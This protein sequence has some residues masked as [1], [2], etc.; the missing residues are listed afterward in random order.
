MEPAHHLGVKGPSKLDA[1]KRS[2]PISNGIVRV[3]KRHFQWEA[4]R[5]KIWQATDSPLEV[6]ELGAVFGPLFI[7][8]QAEIQ[9]LEAFAHG[10]CSQPVQAKGGWRSLEADQT[11]VERRQQ[12]F[13]LHV[14]DSMVEVSH[15]K[16]TNH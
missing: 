15:P 8:Q 13:E 11:G 5:Y 4:D 7:G 14:R 1:A 2:R 3:E 6:W 16:D 12:S 10:Q 9:L